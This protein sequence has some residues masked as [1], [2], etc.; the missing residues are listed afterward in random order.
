[1]HTHT[2]AGDPMEY[3]KDLHTFLM[4][5]VS[6]SSSSLSIVVDDP[7]L[8]RGKY[9][10]IDDEFLFVKS[11][12][13]GVL[14]VNMYEPYPKGGSCSCSFAGVASGGDACTCTGNAGTSCTEGGT[15][16][17]SG[18]T[19]AG[20][21]GTFTTSGGVI[22]AVAVVQHGF[23]PREG[24]TIL[25]S[26]GGTGCA[27]YEFYTTMTNNI[28][29][30]KRGA[31]G[32]KAAQHE[33][34]AKVFTILWPSQFTPKRP[35][36]RYNFR[37]AA[38]NTAGLSEWLYYDMKLYN[39]FPRKI[40]AKGNIPIEIV[41]VGGGTA[42]SAANYTVYIG[43]TRIDDG[44]IDLG[45]SKACTSLM[46]LD[47]AGTKLSVRSP[48]WVGKAHDLIVHYKSG[49]FEHFTV[50]ANWIAYEPPKISSVTPALLERGLAVN[51]TLLGENFGNNA[52]DVS[53]HLEGMTVLPCTPFILMNDGQGICTLIPDQ[54][55]VLVGNIIVEVG[56]EWSGGSQKTSASAVNFVKEKPQPVQVESVLP[57]DITGIPE[58][59]REREVLTT[60][61]KAD[62][63]KALGVPS[64]R[65][66]IQE[67]V[68]G[69]V[70][71]IFVILPD[72]SS[73][74]SPSP[75]SLAANLAMQAEDSNSALRQTSIGASIT[76]S[77]PPN[78]NSILGEVFEHIL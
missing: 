5:R 15:L 70:I 50:G 11:Q 21:E 60:S 59:S 73:V 22:D 31:L 69:S 66:S 56:S 78:I 25:I 49:I 61:F 13:R 65:I 52:S 41:L 33:K 14:S 12:R 74:S 62:V 67:I 23:Y 44:Q 10:R 9:I 38:Y 47:E 30:V 17:G 51:V 26:G 28:L 71:I 64:W 72:T 58:G 27:G 36:K 4:T 76:V 43:H 16:S 32:S 63:S 8:L 35:G 53:G 57:I 48:S 37:I 24:P 77:V 40:A 6:S 55:D 39:V 29:D 42:L 3:P 34:G 2:Y 54:D 19:G 20:F 46:V 7:T 18:G 75:A 1:M 68:A 45:R